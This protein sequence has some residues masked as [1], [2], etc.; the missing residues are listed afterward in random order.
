MDKIKPLFTAT[1]MARRPRNVRFGSLADIEAAIRDV[2]FTPKSGH[3]HR[4]HRCLLSAICGHAS[5]ND[6]RRSPELFEGDV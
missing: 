1:A 4:R 2:C 6:L 5:E 3:A